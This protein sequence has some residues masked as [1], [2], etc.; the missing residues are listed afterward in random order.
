MSGGSDGREDRSVKVAFV[1]PGIG[2]VHR[3]AEAFVVEIA[4]ALAG[5][6]GFDTTIFSRAAPDGAGA[7]AGTGTGASANAVAGAGAAGHHPVWAL[8]RDTRWLNRLY[9]A[10]RFGRKVLDTLFLDP[11]NV[12]WYTAALSAFPALWRGRYDVV[13][14]EGGLVGAW[15]SRILRRLRGTAFIDVAHGLDPKWEG[16][17]ARQRPDRVVTFTRAAAEMIAGRAPRARVAVIPHGIDLETFHPG[18]APADTGLPG[19]VVMAAGAVDGHKRIDLALDAVAAL[20]RRGREVSFLVLGRGPQGEALD[21]RAAGTLPAGRYRRLTVPRSEM[22]RWY[23]AADVFTLPSLTESFGLTYLEAMAC[24]RPCVAPDDPVRREVVA[25]G[26]GGAE[27]A[28]GGLLADPTDPEAYADALAAALDRDWGDAP[29]R[30]AE[31]FPVTAT[32]EG[33]AGLLREVTA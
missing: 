13:V 12:E 11:L 20:H 5:R 8:D 17:F 18:A 26:G 23:A 32:V 1:M 9:A 28:A 31:A 10:T 29:R 15:L 2:V 7:G 4:S 19:P 21:R 6:P 27:G 25:G 33:W 14:M 30:R 3:G 24:G 16:A 22:P